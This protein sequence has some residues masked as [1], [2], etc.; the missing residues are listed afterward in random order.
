MTDVSPV[1][2]APQEKPSNPFSRIVGVLF[3]PSN[4]FAEIARRP[5]W[6]VPAIVILVA[7]FA[8]TMATMPHIDFEGTYREAFEKK[9]NMAPAQMEQAIR[10]A[11]AFGRATQYVGPFL[12]LGILAVLAL[13][14]WLG[15]RLFGGTSTYYQTFSV[16]L[17]GWIPQAIR[18][19]I[20]IP[21]VMT[22]QSIKM[23]ESEAVVRS[24]LNFLVSYRDNPVLF[25]FLSR[26][27][28]FALWSLIL[29]V[30][31]LAVASR[32]SK[33]KTAAVVIAA[34][35]LMTLVIVGATAMG[36]RSR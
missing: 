16:V 35:I 11:V 5:D 33:G 14:Y 4:T 19:L 13:I 34:W 28:V 7:V 3:S 32:L 17:Y 8:A 24:S 26:I 12:L 31:G 15:A 9:G 25:A 30:I 1:A 21:I 10:F 18:A 20:K 29:Y 6:V 2:E 36:A 27:D 22:K 23:Q